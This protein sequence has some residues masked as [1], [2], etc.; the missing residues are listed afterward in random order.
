MELILFS[1]VVSLLFLAA[2]TKPKE[3]SGMPMVASGG[4]LMFFGLCAVNGLLFFALLLQSFF[5]FVVALA[6][7]LGNVRVRF[8]RWG[9]RGAMGLSYTIAFALGFGTL[10]QFH[11]LRQEFPV[12]SITP[13]LAY[14]SRDSF[15]AKQHLEPFHLAP[16]VVQR[17]NRFE[18]YSTRDEW[19]K[20]TLARLHDW[21]FD[22]F[23]IA[24]GFGPVRMASIAGIH[25]LRKETQKPASELI[26]L[27][28]AAYGESSSLPVES[29]SAS[30]AGEDDVCVAEYDS[31]QTLFS[32]H[33][34]GL[35]DFFKPSRMGYVRDRD[36]VVGFVPHRF[37]RVPKPGRG[38]GPLDPWMITRL[39]LVGLSKHETPVAYI[40]EHIP[41]MDELRDAPTRP[42]DHFEQQALDR[43]RAAED[44]VIDETTHRI[45]MVGALRASQNCLQCHSVKRGEL[46]GAFTYE[47][48]P[49]RALPA[50]RGAAPS[51]PS[52][53]RLPG[54]KS[55]S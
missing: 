39:E 50:G 8:A 44:L 36:H 46:L 52:A 17:L 21:T 40:A 28:S 5:S 11:E 37:D 18:E 47:L 16:D 45:R 24:Q 20:W 2:L 49:A 29:I 6:C 48:V 7:E 26:S 23:V 9:F 34:A 55:R 3:S 33:D 54:A 12:E 1:F 13:R 51:E 35:E 10:R 15:G 30:V 14:E 25:R 19:H 4:A 42:L 38:V 32:L 53:S 41:Q 22:Q 27:P 31:R 43:L